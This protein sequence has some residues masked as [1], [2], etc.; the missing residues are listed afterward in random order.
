MREEN[1]SI[2]A[3]ANVA[4]ASSRKKPIRNKVEQDVITRELLKQV[5]NFPQ[6]RAP[7]IETLQCV[8]ARL[9][10]KVP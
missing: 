5:M 7:L 8:A 1:D 9:A 4:T 10:R 3:A 6:L 2:R